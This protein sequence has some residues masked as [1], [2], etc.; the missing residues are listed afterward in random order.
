MPICIVLNWNIDGPIRFG[1][2]LA[3][4][5]PINQTNNTS[6]LCLIVHQT[7]SYSFMKEPADNKQIKKQNNKS[8]SR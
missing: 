3:M 4:S 5:P 1:E 7:N 2:H 6:Y 8:E